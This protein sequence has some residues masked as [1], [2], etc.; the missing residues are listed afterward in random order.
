[1]TT[2]SI[3]AVVAGIAALTAVFVFGVIGIERT[4]ASGTQT[5]LCGTQV[6]VTV[7]GDTVRLIGTDTGALA[8][9]DRARVGVLCVA[10]VVGIQATGTDDEADGGSS[11]VQLRWRLW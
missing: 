8:V 11:S 1:M 10:E 9:G 5:Q 3:I 4:V 2:V 7:S 6:G